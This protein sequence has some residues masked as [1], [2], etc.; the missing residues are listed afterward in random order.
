MTSHVSMKVI[1]GLAAGVAGFM[2]VGSYKAHVGTWQNDADVKDRNVTMA[3][4]LY[5]EEL[6]HSGNKY[7]PAFIHYLN[8][9]DML[10]LHK[11]R[12]AGAYINGFSRDVIWNNLL[13][14]TLGTLAVVWGFNLNATKAL[15]KLGKA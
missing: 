9:P 3:A 6:T 2:A 10:F 5:R 13:P 15:S 4:R 14:L 11:F 1:S 7:V 12:R 8:R